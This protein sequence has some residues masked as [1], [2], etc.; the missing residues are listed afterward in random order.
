MSDAS[1]HKTASVEVLFPAKVLEAQERGAEFLTSANEIVAKSAAAIGE[2]Q[3]EF[4]R[5]ETEQAAKAMV[6]PTLGKDPG[7]ALATYGSQW[8]ENSEK[9]IGQ[10]RAVNDLVRDCGWQLFKLC[11]DAFRQPP[12]QP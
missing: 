11:T 10:M 9:L 3:S 12:K 7:A 1:E 4:L 8:H 2:S 5:L 6:P